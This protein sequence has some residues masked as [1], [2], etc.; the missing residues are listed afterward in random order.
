MMTFLYPRQVDVKGNEIKEKIRLKSA[1]LKSLLVDWLT[2]LLY[3]SDAE[4]ACCSE[5]YFEK[6]NEDE[7]VAT[8]YGR[9][10]RAKEDIKAIISHELK[11]EKGENNWQAIISF[12]I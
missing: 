11:I 3:L 4:K 10:V 6:L 5:F 12:R 8:V 7:L 2:E 1:G 9:R